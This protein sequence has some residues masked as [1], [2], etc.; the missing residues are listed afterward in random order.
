M[1]RTGI[2]ALV[3]RKKRSIAYPARHNPK[4][5]LSPY[6]RY[7]GQD[8][9][10]YWDIQTA[11]STVLFRDLTRP[12]RAGEFTRFVCEPP[13]PLMR[14]YHARVPWY[15]DV[16]AS[17]NP[18]GVTFADLFEEIYKVMHIQIVDADFNND[19]LDDEERKRITAAYRNRVGSDRAEA[20]KGIRRVDFLMGRFIFEGLVKGKEGLWEMKTT[21][22]IQLS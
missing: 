18:V 9:P 5:V 19:E 21:K 7:N 20:M 3:H 2:S 17:G 8:P 13:A 12:P 10:V 11:P 16:R 22:P 15:V 4:A 14:I 6:L 1:P